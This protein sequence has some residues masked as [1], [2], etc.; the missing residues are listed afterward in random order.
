MA[1]GVAKCGKVMA[2]T[3]CMVQGACGGVA[4][5]MHVCTMVHALA[6][7]WSESTI[8]LEQYAQA[9]AASPSTVAQAPMMSTP[10]LRLL[11]AQ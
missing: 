1:K 5:S 3:A 9:Q 11:A 2:S 8:S 6:Q 10:A 7:H 4:G